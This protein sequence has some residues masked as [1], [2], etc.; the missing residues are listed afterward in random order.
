MRKTLVLVGDGMGDYPIP[1]L[2]NRTPL[3]AAAIPNM[4]RVAGAGET[5]LLSTVPD[6]MAPGSDVAN[7][8]LMGLDPRRYYTGRA[9]IEAAG[10]GI[11][12]RENDVA[13]RCNL[14]TV[15]N[16]IIRDHSAGH[17]STSLLFSMD[18]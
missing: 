6:G 8:S 5:R 2:G 14:V 9:P 15:T 7:V 17:I 3:Q 11:A 18:R 1:E 4:R 12:M 13:F 10:A 16:G